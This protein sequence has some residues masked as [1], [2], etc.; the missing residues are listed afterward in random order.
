MLL[1]LVAGCDSV[2]PVAAVDP[3]ASVAVATSADLAVAWQAWRTS[4]IDSYEVAAELS[5]ECAGGDRV[6]VRDGQVVRTH[7]RDREDA[8]TI[9]RI[10]FMALRA[11]EQAEARPADVET[12]VRLSAGRPQIPVLVATGVTDPR[13]ADGG[14]RLTVPGFEAR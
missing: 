12:R 13:V 1:L 9:D 4:G 8:L 2:N 10:Y 6:T 5:C 7:R 14:Y 11:L 3:E